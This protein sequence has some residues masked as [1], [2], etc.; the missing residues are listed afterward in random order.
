MRKIIFILPVV[1]LPCAAAAAP[2]A[3]VMAAAARLPSVTEPDHRATTLRQAR[4]A[5]QHVVIIMQENRSFDSYFGTFPGAANPN[6]NRCMPLDPANPKAGCITAFH[7]P[8]DMNGGGPHRAQEAQ[9]DIDDGITT[10]RMDGFLLQESLFGIGNCVG[11]SLENCVAFR[12]GIASHDV[13]GYHTAEDIP[14]YWAYA[15]S[16]V[17]QSRMFAGIRSW[18][19][20]SHIE[21]TSEW[22]AICSNPAQAMSCAT[23]PTPAT[24]AANLTL[25]W[26]NL[27]HLLDL[28][29]VTWKYYIGTGFE[30]DC[31]DDAMSCA[32]RPQQ[33]TMGGIWN[34]AP[35]YASVKAGGATYLASHNPPGNKF[36]ADLT[37]RTLPQVSWII[38][39][40]GVSEHPPASITAGMEYVTAL[41]NAVMQSPYWANTAIFVSWDDWGGFYDHVTPPNVDT[42]P[43]ANPIQG[44]G[45]RVP[46]LMISAYARPHSIDNAV[47]SFDSYARFIEDLFAGSARLD[48]AK[49]GNPDNRPTIRDE[50]TSVSFLHG[51]TAPIGDLVKE[52][53]FKQP[54]LPPLIL[55]TAIPT[56]LTAACNASKISFLCQSAAVSLSWQAVPSGATGTPPYTYAVTRDGTPV[57]ACATTGTTCSDTTPGSG[58]HLYRISSTDSA[59]ISSPASAAVEADIP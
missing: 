21:M 22:S 54:P 20:P 58:K 25:P 13:A 15:A 18:S 40:R 59:G 19:W 49:L 47:L 38:P 5:I 30:P 33:A 14:N 23:T 17:L 41:V 28:H 2:P 39:D 55:S 57:P 31:A 32:P 34:P 52:F 11:L 36:F 7:D 24:P 45:L 50:L 29:G 46:G 26:E 1:A 42:N 37:A 44:F 16:F 3:A 27:F 10:A 9:G 8:H 53:D 43:T 51:H 56:G 48:P 4:A 12:Q 35:F 6:I